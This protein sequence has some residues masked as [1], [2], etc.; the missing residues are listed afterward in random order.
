MNKS[1]LDPISP[2]KPRETAPVYPIPETPEHTT[3]PNPPVTAGTI[4]FQNHSTPKIGE[5]SL[6]E[7]R[8]FLKTAT[9]NQTPVGVEGLIL[10]PE[11][12]QK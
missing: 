9:N 7:L 3:N 1:V 4:N 8:K 12:Q 5:R 2:T 11:S 10:E 6:D